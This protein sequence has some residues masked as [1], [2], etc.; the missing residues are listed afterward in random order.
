MIFLI[1]ITIFLDF[2]IIYFGNSYFNNINLF[3]PMLTLTLIVFLY[4]KVDFKKYFKTA[5]WIGFLYDLIFSYIFLF[6]ALIF[7]LFAKIIKKVDK[8]IK[9][10]LLV[11]IILVIIF[12]FIYDLV[13]FL[14]VKISNYNIVTLSDLFYKFRNSLLLNIIYFLLLNILFNGKSF[15]SNKEIIFEQI[16]INIQ[17]F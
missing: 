5:F 13:L 6:H 12:I 7:L 4:N 3:Y 16:F 1:L 8:Y 11:S 9:C 14:L 10:N 2:I 15:K 17:K